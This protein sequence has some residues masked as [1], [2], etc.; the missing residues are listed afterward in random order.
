VS[1]AEHPRATDD[2]RAAGGIDSSGT[3]AQ[4]QKLSSAQAIASPEFRLFLQRGDV[5]VALGSGD[6]LGGLENL[7]ALPL[8]EQ[9]RRLKNEVFRVSVVT[10]VLS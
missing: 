10:T 4:S 7:K 6:F 3:T 9:R 5:E 8:K 1:T 2:V